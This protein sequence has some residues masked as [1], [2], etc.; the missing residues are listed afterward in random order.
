MRA[1]SMFVV[2][3]VVISSM[4]SCSKSS[5]NEEISVGNRKLP[6]VAAPSFGENDWPWW[7]GPHRDGRAIGESYPTEWSDTKNVIWK[8]VIPGRGHSSPTVVGD[9]IFVATAEKKRRVQTVICFD[10]NDGSVRWRKDVHQGPLGSMGHRDSSYASATPACDGERIFA[11]FRHDGQVYVTAL[12]TEGEQLWQ[13]KVGSHDSQWGYAPSPVIHKELVIV[14]A[15]S[16]KQGFIA[17]LHRKTGEIWWRKHRPK[18]DAYSSP[19]VAHVAGKDQLFIPGGKKVVSYDPMTGEENWSVDGCAEVTCG[20]MV[21]NDDTVFASGGYNGSETLAIRADG[22]GKVV[23]RTSK[24]DFYV[25]SMLLHEGHIYSVDGG[26]AYCVDAST[27]DV[28]KKL[29][30]GGNYYA[31][32]ILAGGYLY[33]T[34]RGGKVT[35]VN[36][37]PKSFQK[38]TTNQL[39]E[40]AEATPVACGG[41]LYFRVARTEGGFRKEYLYCIGE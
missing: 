2:G 35:I 32:P 30:L 17:A 23:W 29:R 34:S 6:P 11:V 12:S 38:V 25:P 31:S 16:D 18:A 19:I 8:A 21:W 33:F 36:P 26:V 41:R 40:Q 24:Y 27:G 7:R 9:Q 37:D 13:K 20:T 5:D 10:R 3:I 4:L 14:A 28:V 22:S 1:S 39:G 15:D